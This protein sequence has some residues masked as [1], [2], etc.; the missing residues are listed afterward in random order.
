M[1]CKKCGGKM[2]RRY[3]TVL[4]DKMLNQPYYFGLWYIC[5]KCKMVQLIDKYKVY[6]KTTKKLF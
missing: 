5:E 4:T 1:Q 2:R 6:N 3:H